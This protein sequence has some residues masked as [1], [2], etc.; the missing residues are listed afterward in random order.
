MKYQLRFIE[1][2]DIDAMARAAYSS[3][4]HLADGRMEWLQLM[5][6]MA[7]GGEQLLDSFL[8]LASTAGRKF[9]ERESKREFLKA[10]RKGR[11][12]GLKFFIDRCEE[13]GISPDDYLI[14]SNFNNQPS[15][16]MQTTYPATPPSCRNSMN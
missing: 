12:V 6:S 10:V 7:C 5:M 11:D 2:Y 13:N 14:H 15:T 9:K 8:L 4:V 16:N 3:G 1:K